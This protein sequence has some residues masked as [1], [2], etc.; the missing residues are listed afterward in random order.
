MPVLAE[1]MGAAKILSAKL[2]RYPAGSLEKVICPLK[3]KEKCA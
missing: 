1:G 3:V 2:P